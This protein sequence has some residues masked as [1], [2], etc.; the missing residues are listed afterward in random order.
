MRIN[1]TRF[2]ST[3][4]L[5]AKIFLV[6]GAVWFAVGTSLGLFSAIH[7]VAPDFF[8]NIAFIEFGRVRPAHT[9]TVLFG[10]VTGMLIGAGV[11]ILPKVLNTRLFSEPMG[12]V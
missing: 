11:Y 5:T 8:A 3:E 9:N 1:L 10:F 6:S 7:L 12:V 4:Y 2:W